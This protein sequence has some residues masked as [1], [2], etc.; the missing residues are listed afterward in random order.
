M[1][2]KGN[3]ELA[4]K[5]TPAQINLFPGSIPRLKGS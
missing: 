1:E 4:N 5:F 2:G 3:V